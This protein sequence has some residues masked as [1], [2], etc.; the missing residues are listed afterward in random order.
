MA[1]DTQSDGRG[2]ARPG[3]GRPRSD[4]EHANERARHSAAYWKE[5]AKRERHLAAIAEA[6]SMARMGQYYDRDE[7]R[8]T[9]QTM[10]SALTETMRTIPD[11]LERKTGLTPDQA[12]FEAHIIDEAL[13]TA[14]ERVASL[15]Q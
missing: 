13:D 15:L 4:N 9:V 14:R 10:L 12:A 1:K 8:R 2:G 5:K 11:L 3:A 6:E 7:V